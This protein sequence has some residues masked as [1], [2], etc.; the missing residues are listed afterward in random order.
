M[1]EQKLHPYKIGENYLV[2]TVTFHYTGRLMEV[3]DN[4]IVLKQAAWIA[5]DGRYADAVAKGSYSEVEP[6]PEDREVV[7]GRASIVD[8]VIVTHPLPRTQK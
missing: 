3:Y 6:Y 2:R 8:A 4:E 7:I 5:D 1:S